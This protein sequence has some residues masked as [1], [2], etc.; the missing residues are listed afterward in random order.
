MECPKFEEPDVCYPVE[1]KCERDASGCISEGQPLYFATS[2][3]S[4]TV[5]RGNASAFRLTD[6]DFA[7]LVAEAFA[8]WTNVDCGGGS[9]PGVVVQSAGLVTARSPYF[10]ADPERN[11]NTWFLTRPWTHDA[12]MLGYETS[13]SSTVT[14]EVFDA[15]VDLNV[16]KLVR[17]FSAQD[18]RAV[19]LAVATHEAG[20]FLGLAHSADESALMFE[21]YSP[22]SLAQRTLTQDDIDGICALYPPS[23][24]P[25][26]C[27]T[28]S[29]P[30]GSLDGSACALAST[31]GAG[32]VSP[33]TTGSS[34]KGC[35]YSPAAASNSWVV[36]FVI[37]AAL[38]IGRRRRADTHLSLRS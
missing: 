17:D 7:A 8:R 18:L 28:P 25:T 31:G 1:V 29:V 27:A 34:K 38:A 37:Y 21:A 5:A 19:L 4:Y 22:L 12:A 11:S 35:S 15:D 20:H 2:C 14:G 33:P 26:N 16:D 32:A 9:R 10:C 3:L 24:A 13:S 36:A 6:D 30:D 23:S